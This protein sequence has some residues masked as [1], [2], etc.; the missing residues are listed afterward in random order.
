MRLLL[1]PAFGLTLF[2]LLPG[3]AAISALSGSDPLDVYDLRPAPS[4]GVAS[5]R[6]TRD[7]VIEEP[8]TRGALATD[9]ILI[10]PNPLQA[11]YLP[12]GRWSD[13]TPALVQTQLVRAFE[14][15]GALRYVGRRPLG[16]SGDYA[17]LSEITDFQAELQPDGRSALVRIRLSARLVRE[18]DTGILG[19]RVFEATALSAS[20]DTLNIVSAFDTAAA[21]LVP[22]IAAWGLGAM[23]IAARAPGT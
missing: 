15:T 14:D 19:A 4:L 11:Q 6:P 21:A 22:Q 23:G 13:E 9:R 3:C 12:D 8:T 18:A 20:T 5:A 10:R 2:A 7:L 17:L 16:L 1:S